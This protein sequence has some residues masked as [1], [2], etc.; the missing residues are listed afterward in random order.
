MLSEVDGAGLVARLEPEGWSCGPARSRRRAAE[1]GASGDGSV[2]GGVDLRPGSNPYRGGMDGYSISQVAERTGFPATTL[3]F[4]EQSGLV[5]PRR[6][7]AGY[8]CYD[9]ADVEL[10]AF[11][12]RAKG[13]GLSLEEITELLA[14]LDAEECRPVQG[15]LRDLVEAKIADARA[16][17]AELTAFTL[18]LQRFAASLDRH[19]P[20][21]PCD[22]ACGCTTEPDGATT[23]Q[24]V[25]L[26]DRPPLPGAEPVIACTLSPERVGDRLVEWQSTARS[27]AGVERVEGGSRLRF[28]R[29]ADAAAL[30][31]LIAAEQDCC[32][33]LTFRLTV[34]SDEIT[35][36]VIG[37]DGTQPVIDA[38]VG[39]PT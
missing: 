13:F 21:G 33:F 9:D 28:G 12:G 15:R 14:L 35:L 22:D 2:G 11:I 29:G 36:D 19:T 32:S 20:D 4:Y 16:R 23:S 24:L 30:A 17:V 38:L 5:R 34:G 39:A 8:R 10:L 31:G 3:R 18:E 37:P 7:S 6:T 25:A 26:T 1:V 27:A